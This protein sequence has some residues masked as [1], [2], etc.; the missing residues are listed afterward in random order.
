MKVTLFIPCFV[1]LMF[2]RVGI[3]MVE[4][5]ERLGHTVECPESIACCGQ[6]AY[7]SG[8]WD[9]A[10][11]VAAKA[12]N[13]LA[14]A[15]VALRCRRVR[16]DAARDGRRLHVGPRGQRGRPHRLRGHNEKL[17]N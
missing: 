4:I 3:S 14:G 1:D 8:Y 15:E 9:E 6:P 12:L 10:R 13:A 11:V 16:A 2:P 5:L 17:T 7:N